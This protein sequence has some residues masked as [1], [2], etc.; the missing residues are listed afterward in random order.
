MLAYLVT[1]CDLTNVIIT[2]TAAVG[3][4]L[5]RT[6]APFLQKRQMIRYDEKSVYAW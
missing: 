5:T 3:E 4:G 2:T 1:L 6:V